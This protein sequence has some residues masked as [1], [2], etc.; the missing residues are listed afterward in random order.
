MTPRAAVLLKELKERRGPVLFRLSGG[1]C[2]GTVPLCLRQSEF[3]IGARDVLLDTVEGV[4]F[5]VDE[6]MFRYLRNEQ[7]TLDAVAAISDSFSLEAA[8]DMRF[9]VQTICPRSS[10]P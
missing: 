6:Q 3:R 5:Y 1:C 10:T 8:G 9:V 2:D 7:M 4:P